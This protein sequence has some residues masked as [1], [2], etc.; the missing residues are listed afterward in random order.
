MLQKYVVLL[1]FLKKSTPVQHVLKQCS[2]HK[3]LP[4]YDSVD[5]YVQCHIF[6]E[7]SSRRH[8]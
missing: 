8:G 6:I 1:I 3:S 4:V 5:K 2:Y 7:Q